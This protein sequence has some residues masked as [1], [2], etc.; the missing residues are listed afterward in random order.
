MDERKL[1]TAL[2]ESP[3]AIIAVDADEKVAI[4]NRGAEVMFGYSAPEIVG[5]SIG[6]LIP[7]GVEGDGEV[8]EL[9]QRLFRDGFVRNYRTRRQT[10]DGRRVLVEATMTPIT[11]EDGTSI[12][13]MLILRDI[14]N[15]EKLH[16]D[17]LYAENL[18]S[19]GEMAA[20]LA[21]E[22]KNDLAGISGAIQVI[23]NSIEEG[24]ARRE[25]MSEILTQV[26]KL[27]TSVRDLLTLARPTA[28][29]LEDANV[30][31]IVSEAISILKSEPMMK[32]VEI[33]R[34]F[35]PEVC[36][37]PLDTKQIS[38]VFMNI[39]L[40]AAQAMPMGGK[41]TIGVAETAD[42]IAISFADTGM[43]MPP[44]VAAS[45]FTPFFTTKPTGSGV[46]LSISKRIV[47]A[48]GG[49]IELK[50]AVGEG[51]TLT[52]RL[53]KRQSSRRFHEQRKHPGSRR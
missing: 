50:S 17:L 4:W 2:M 41:L 30:C 13:S 48:H 22:I 27:D 5:R 45:A 12:G 47:E 28:P 14:S 23:K 51:T 33:V 42:E 16:E 34:N 3:D 35:P 40:N 39:M 32:A 44:D 25:V 20:A 9:T 18:A 52:V 36:H 38:Q 53:P 1:L 26:K 21:H 19:M 11:D 24:D 15:V 49:R 31:F 6:I 46:G 37:V 29:Q 7:P 8:V 43:G 10:K